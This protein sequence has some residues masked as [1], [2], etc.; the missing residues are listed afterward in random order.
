MYFLVNY[1]PTTKKR[2]L[3]EQIEQKALKGQLK[4]S[5]RKEDIVEYKVINEYDDMES[6]NLEK[7]V[8]FLDNEYDLEYIQTKL[9]ELDN[10]NT[11]VSFTPDFSFDSNEQ[12]FNKKSILIFE[13]SDINQL[14]NK[15]IELIGKFKNNYS[16]KKNQLKKKINFTCVHCFPKNTLIEADFENYKNNNNYSLIFYLSNILKLK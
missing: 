7:N 5:S 13:A 1:I 15:R 16:L 12:N 6:F 14:Q 9:N 4:E 3:K 2:R 10:T 11:D 8:Q